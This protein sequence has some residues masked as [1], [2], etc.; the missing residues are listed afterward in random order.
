MS[1]SKDK[2]QRKQQIEAGTDKRTLAKAKEKAQH[3]KTVVTYSVVAVLLVIFFAFIFLYNSSLPARYTTA[4]TVD[5]EDYSVAQLNYYYATSYMTFYNTYGSYISYFFDTNTSLADQAYSE[6]MSW[7]DYF[8]DSAVQDMAQIQMLNDEAE[9]AGFT[10]D[11]QQQATLDEQLASLETAWE[12]LGYSNLQQYLNLN[13][14]KGVDKALAEQ[15]LTRTFIASAY[16]QSVYDG[17]EYSATDLADYYSEHADELD[18]I[19]YAYYTVTKPTETEE[20]TETEDGTEIDDAAETEE[21]VET[22]E[23]AEAEDAAETEDAADAEQTEEPVLDVQAA[24]EAID[25][26]DEETF[27]EYLEQNVGEGTAPTSLSQAGA[28]LSSNYSEWLLDADR[29]PGDATAIETD[30]ADYVVMFLGRDTN[31]YPTVSFRHILVMAEDADSDGEISDGEKQ[32]AEDEARELYK[33]WQDGDA[34]EDSF[35]EL[36]N[37]NSDDSGSN[38]N[39]G[40]YEDVY[41]GTMVEPINDWL[42]A[43]GRKAG[44]TDVVSYDGSNYTGTHVLYFVGQDDMT[45]AESQADGALRNDAYNSWQ[46]EHM[47]DYEPVVTSHLSMAGKI[48]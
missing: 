30:S 11:E 20:T 14:G 18:V 40:L 29:E 44:D 38:T 7:R 42:F 3:R 23:P 32:A 26:T 12:D 24:A 33:Q 45:Y 46:E 4:V 9:A 27:T 47:T 35:A 48:H 21:P 19:D 37:E 28:S 15:E 36:A 2:L 8:L 10:L 34:T 31:D 6:D 1:A 25:G 16:S 41:K 13:Y 43:D 5:G 17:F 39:G 22:E